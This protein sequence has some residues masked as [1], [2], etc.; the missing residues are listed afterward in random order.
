[1]V[2]SS[3]N[4]SKNAI[5]LEYFTLTYGIFITLIQF[6]SYIDIG[7][8]KKFFVLFIKHIFLNQITNRKRMIV[9]VFI[10]LVVVKLI[11]GIKKNLFVG[12]DLRIP[13]DHHANQYS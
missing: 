10:L 12:V 3:N 6:Y 9:P 8:I 5:N 2:G 13:P 11:Y 7:Y 4:F 1:M